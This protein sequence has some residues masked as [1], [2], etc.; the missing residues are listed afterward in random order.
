MRNERSKKLLYNKTDIA[1]ML[2]V[3]KGVL[4][5]TCEVLKVVELDYKDPKQRFTEA[6]VFEILRIFKSRLTDD[7]ISL[8]IHA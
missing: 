4:R 1:T 7:E 3:S 5:R 6:Q 8:L 2:G